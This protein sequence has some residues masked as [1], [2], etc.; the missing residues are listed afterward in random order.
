[1]KY[2]SSLKIWIQLH[3]PQFL[4]LFYVQK[5]YFQKRHFRTVFKLWRKVVFP[6]KFLKN[7]RFGR[8]TP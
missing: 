4:S 7:V 6:H 3:E 8:K 2:L 1:M 5:H